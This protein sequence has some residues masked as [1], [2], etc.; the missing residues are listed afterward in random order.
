V[1]CF[2]AVRV[3]E[4]VRGQLEAVI[5][6]LRPAV[7]GARFVCPEVLHMTL[8]FFAALEEDRVVQVAEAA[9]EGAGQVEP[10]EMAFEGF[11]VFPGPDRPRVLWMGLQR[12]GWQVETLQRAIG[13]SLRALGL[14]VED[15]PFR[16]HLTLAR[17]SGPS[18]EAARVLAGQQRQATSAFLVREVVLF[19]SRL[20]PE[21]PE[22]LPRLTFPLGG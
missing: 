12:G 4:E 14:P 19:E 11:G 16:P 21:G 2:L 15:R 6:Q 18:P 7:P 1:R 8:H 20:H 13:N 10:F 9:R 5:R 17:F 22:H 3:S